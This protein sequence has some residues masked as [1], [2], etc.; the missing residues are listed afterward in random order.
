MQGTSS[1][2]PWAKLKNPT[3]RFRALPSEHGIQRTPVAHRCWQM[4]RPLTM[5]STSCALQIVKIAA[6][7]GK[8]KVGRRLPQLQA[9]CYRPR[10]LCMILAQLT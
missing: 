5:S 8:S 10:Q 3:V 4:I 2:A 7:Q 6:G 1:S 9:L